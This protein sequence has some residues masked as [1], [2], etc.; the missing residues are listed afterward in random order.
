MQQTDPLLTAGEREVIHDIESS[1]A[2]IKRRLA[3]RGG[4]P[5]GVDGFVYGG[6]LG[7]L[8]E[9]IPFGRLTFFHEPHNLDDEPIQDAPKRRTG[10]PNPPVWR[11]LAVICACWLLTGFMLVGAFTA[12]RGLLRL[13]G[14][15]A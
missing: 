15:G 11:M 10:P 8:P 6:T 14:V 3:L 2:V 5:S 7:S 1:R 4:M 12:I 13:L 9:P